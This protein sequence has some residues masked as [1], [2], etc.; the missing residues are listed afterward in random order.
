MS[1]EDYRKAEKLFG[2]TWEIM[3]MDMEDFLTAGGKNFLFIFTGEEYDSGVLARATEVNIPNFSKEISKETSVVGTNC[4]PFSP[5]YLL[6][7]DQHNID[8]ILMKTRKIK[9]GKVRISGSFLFDMY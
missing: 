5:F 6:P 8:E 3:K 1:A 9:K 7:I 4:C 2:G